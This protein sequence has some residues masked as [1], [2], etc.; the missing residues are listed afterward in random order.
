MEYQLTEV[1]RREIEEITIKISEDN[2][3]AAERWHAVLFKK[4]EGL[5]QFPR[6]GRRRDDVRTGVYYF[7]YDNYLI[8]YD[9][10]DTAV[11]VVHVVHGARNLPEVFH[12]EEA[13][14]PTPSKTR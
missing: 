7:P 5:V 13:E 4:F 12:S 8:F 11:V 6:M 1:A 14:E 9:I 3:F 2:L 10:T